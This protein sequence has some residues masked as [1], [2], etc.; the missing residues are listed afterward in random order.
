MAFSPDA[1][2][3]ETFPALLMLLIHRVRWENLGDFSNNWHS[4]PLPGD[5]YYGEKKNRLPSSYL[6]NVFSIEAAKPADHYT[7]IAICLINE[8]Y[9]CMHGMI[10]VSLFLHTLLLVCFVSKYIFWRSIYNRRWSV[11]LVG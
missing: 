11:G 4:G 7:P 5:C 8:I 10:Q 1:R 2:S 9:A 6:H 3:F